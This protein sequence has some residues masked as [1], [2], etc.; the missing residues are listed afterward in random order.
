MLLHECNI[1]ATLT[2][3]VSS[4]GGCNSYTKVTYSHHVRIHTISHTLH[5]VHAKNT[6]G[7]DRTWKYAK[8]AGNHRALLFRVRGLSVT[9][10]HLVTVDHLP[11]RFFKTIV[12]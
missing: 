3:I 10:L 5:I 12:E 11:T 2:T 1:P 6:M 9:E 8:I 4:C 7:G